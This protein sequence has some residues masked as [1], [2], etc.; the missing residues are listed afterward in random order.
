LKVAAYFFS[1]YFTPWHMH[2]KTNRSCTF[3]VYRLTK[4]DWIT[5]Q[6]DWLRN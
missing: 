6:T 4:T 2:H 3:T 1:Q 5:D